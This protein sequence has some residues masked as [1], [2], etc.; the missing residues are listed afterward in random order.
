M[1]W[2]DGLYWSAIAVGYGSEMIFGR[3]DP[4]FLWIDIISLGVMAVLWYMI[5]Q[6]AS[7]I[8]KWIFAVLAIF[9]ASMYGLAFVTSGFGIE[10]LDGIWQ[11]MSSPEQWVAGVVH[12]LDLCG[13]SCLFLKSSQI[14]FE[15]NGNIVA[16]A[17]HLTDIF[18]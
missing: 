12:L 2:F 11:D 18:K 8:F 16:E 5:A 13:V 15:S 6:R 17:D 4:D 3:L 14:W 1:V 10:F 7:N 9:S